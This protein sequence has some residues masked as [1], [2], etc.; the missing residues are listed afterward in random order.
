[1][2]LMAVFQKQCI[3]ESCGFLADARRRRNKLC[4]SSSYTFNGSELILKPKKCEVLIHK[5]GRVILPDYEMG[6]Q[7]LMP[8]S[9]L[10]ISNVIS[11]GYK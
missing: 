10:Y 2:M 1:M 11:K 6:P 4:V 3:L 7:I 8:K 5:G 9:F